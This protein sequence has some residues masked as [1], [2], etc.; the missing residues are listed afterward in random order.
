MAKTPSKKSAKPP[1]ETR[2]PRGENFARYIPQF[3]FPPLSCAT[4]SYRYFAYYSLNKSHAKALR[5]VQH[6]MFSRNNSSERTL[7]CVEVHHLIYARH[8]RHLWARCSVS[9]GENISG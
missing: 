9:C 7:E 2:V 5:M 3:S 8:V 1:H 6:S 4:Q